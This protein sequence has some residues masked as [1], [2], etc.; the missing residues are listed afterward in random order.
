M[1]RCCA[2]FRKDIGCGVRYCDDGDEGCLCLSF[3]VWGIL[4]TLGVF[5][6]V[7]IN[8]FVVSEHV[9][10]Q[11]F[12]DRRASNFT[13]L[14]LHSNGICHWS[15]ATA[16]ITADN[17][18]VELHYPPVA[19]YVLCRSGDR[20]NNFFAPFSG[21]ETFTVYKDPSSDYAIV[22][23]LDSAVGWWIGLVASCLVLIA[24]LCAWTCAF[25]DYAEKARYREREEGQEEIRD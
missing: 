5:V 3:C 2:E 21:V 23:F 8:V 13:N 18:T 12:V 17:S 14:Q 22:A 11:S 7:V 15:T 10:T 1:R 16:T 19:K 6:W 9:K 25:N 20:A 4:L 24:L